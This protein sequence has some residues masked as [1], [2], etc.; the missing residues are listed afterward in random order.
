[1][2]RPAPQIIQSEQIGDFVWT[3]AESQA[4]WVIVCYGRPIY[5]IKQHWLLDRKIYPRNTF[6]SEAHAQNLADKLNT[7]FKTQAYTVRKM[8]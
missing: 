3:I 4:A 6:N 8:Q 7:M 5:I 2:S 1:M